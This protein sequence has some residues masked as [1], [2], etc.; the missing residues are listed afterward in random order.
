MGSEQEHSL[1]IIAHTFDY[2]KIRHEFV[3][4]LVNE[5]ASTSRELVHV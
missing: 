4:K 1:G 3:Q 2:L 5:N